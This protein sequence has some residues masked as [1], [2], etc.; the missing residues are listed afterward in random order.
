M[1]NIL[2]ISRK[3][4]NI[5]TTIVLFVMCVLLLL[6]SYNGLNPIDKWYGWYRGILWG[7]LGVLIVHTILNYF[8]DGIIQKISR[9]RVADPCPHLL[10]E[11]CPFDDE[12]KCEYEKSTCLIR[13]RRQNKRTSRPF[14]YILLFVAVVFIFWSIMDDPTVVKEDTNW[15]TILL[16]VSLP[17][18]TSVIAA[19]L[20]S[21]IIDIPSRI[22]EEKSFFIEVLTSNDYIYKALDEKKLTELRLQA[23]RHIHNRYY[24]KMAEGL[25]EVDDKICEMLKMP[26]FINYYQSLYVAKDKEDPNAFAKTVKVAFTAQNPYGK[27]KPI[28]MNLGMGNYLNFK[29]DVISEANASKLFRL[30]SFEISFEEE[31]KKWDIHD[32]IRLGYKRSKVEGLSYNGIV[33]IATQK[34]LNEPI[35]YEF[36]KGGGSVLD[37][38]KYELIADDDNPEL[39]VEFVGKIHVEFEYT[40]TIPKEDNV[41]TKRLKYPAR[42]FHMDYALDDE[43]SN[44]SLV[45]QM[46]GTVIDQNDVIIS[47]QPNG[48]QIT[49]NT[50][51]WLLP[52]NGAVVVHVVRQNNEKK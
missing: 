41:F 6:L 28:R 34:A 10:Y 13:Q 26:Y 14:V 43:I 11:Q 49:M 36:L 20:V 4:I 32:Y 45:G 35:S 42:N 1:K 24:P 3:G 46:I 17:I 2:N 47:T 48:K 52:K 22:M 51:D 25:I 37:S 5:S 29:D 21:W 44:I 8:L 15:L 39:L 50:H 27:E 18:S 9:Y 7:E 30:K 19:V 23:I 12:K 33:M 38:K 31:D 16:K 40:V